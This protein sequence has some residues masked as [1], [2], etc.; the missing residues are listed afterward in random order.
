MERFAEGWRFALVFQQLNQV[1]FAVEEEEIV[2][3]SLKNYCDGSDAEGTGVALGDFIQANGLQDEGIVVPLLKSDGGVA[4][5]SPVQGAC[6][7]RRWQARVP[8]P[9]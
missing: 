9:G 8:P 6:E 5:R 3:R 4:V 2:C 7:T 1:T